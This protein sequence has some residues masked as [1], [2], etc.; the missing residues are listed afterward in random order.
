MSVDYSLYV[1]RESGTFDI[2]VTYYIPG[3]DDPET[4]EQFY[5]TSWNYYFTDQNGGGGT[6]G[7]GWESESVI[8]NMGFPA[9]GT[10]SDGTLDFYAQNNFS[11]VT[12]QMSWHILNA[13]MA[14]SNVTITGIA[15]PDIILGGYGSDHLYGLGGNDLIDG[16]PGDD[17]IEGGEGDDQIYAG[18]GNDMLVGGNGD[19]FYAVDSYGDTIVE[20]ETGGAYDWVIASSNYTLSPYVEG[21]VL[22][23]DARNGIGNDQANRIDGNDA[24]NIIEGRGGDDILVGY[25]GN[26]LLRGDDGDDWL[27]G[28][29]GNDVM[30]GGLGDDHFTINRPEDQ[31]IEL[32]G[33]GTDEVRVSR[34]PSYTLAANLENL[35]YIGDGVK[36]TGIGNAVDNVMNGGNT[37]DILRGLEGDDMLFGGAGNDVLEG[38]IGRDALNGGLGIDTASYANA[39]G[40]V[41]VN[42]LAGTGT[43]GEAIGDSYDSIE[44]LTGSAYDDKLIGNDDANRLMGGA[45]KDQLQGRGGNDWLVGGAGADRLDGGD[46][47]DGVSYFES[48]GGVTVNLR[49]QTA[50]GGD[51]TGDVLISI[52]RVEGSDQIDRLT[53]SD[54]A[55][56]LFG[57]AGNDI[58]DGAGGDDIIRGGQG[59]DTLTGGAGRDMVDYA[60]SSAGV[61]V[62]LITQTATGGD[63]TGDSIS[64]FEKVRGSDHGDTLTGNADA[65]V[66]DGGGGDDVLTGGDGN[67]MIIGGAGADTM[68]GGDGIDTLSFAGSTNQVSVSLETGYI[69][70]LDAFG[71]TFTGFENLRGSEANDVL[72]GSA[73][74]NR[75]EGGAGN[76]WLTG[77]GG[78]DTLY[79]GEGSDIFAYAAGS[80]TD[81]VKDFTVGG[82]VDALY[83]DMGSLFDTFEEVM[84]VA[85][86]VGTNTVFTFGPGQ[87]LIVENAQVGS[88]TVQ[89]IAFPVP[90]EF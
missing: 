64:G 71:D 39:A 48:A 47:D 13:G 7:Y 29:A 18:S 21:L 67:D 54:G 84:A 30:E 74:A 32:A 50:T 27:D 41:T 28:G 58:I 76:D 23:G 11:G 70:G 9:S 22:I 56:Q 87:L 68:S 60:G 57:R 12:A 72:H 40:A 16:G 63:A 69:W 79:G 55:N 52:E 80:D 24:R 10:V 77:A 78:T 85:S 66:L 6:G 45:G 33:Q 4:G 14:N 42:L 59:A 65:N 31:I 38:G 2:Y 83:I 1:D 36:F 26:D 44:W 34:L 73:A 53:G 20:T 8:I 61:T 51:A 19:D 35:T 37:V 90:E 5:E 15:T 89:D 82:L 17:W 49:T 88:F 75:I 46:G 62:N 25:G 81:I 3:Y 43:R 86:Q